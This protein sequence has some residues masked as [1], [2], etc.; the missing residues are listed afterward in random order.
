MSGKA[1]PPTLFFFF[2]G[3]LVIPECSLFYMNFRIT[4]RVP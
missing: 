4:C 3:F 1:G 2:S